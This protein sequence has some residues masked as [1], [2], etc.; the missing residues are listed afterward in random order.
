MLKLFTVFTSTILV[1]LHERVVAFALTT[2]SSHD[3]YR[4]ASEI[5]AEV[6]NVSPQKQ[7][8]NSKLFEKIEDV[9]L[10]HSKNN[11]TIFYKR[12]LM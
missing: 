9:L 5:H 2:S 7:S 12:S 6:R 3:L 8:L 11:E 1:I 4:R 10:W